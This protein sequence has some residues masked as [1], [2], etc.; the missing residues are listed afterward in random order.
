MVALTTYDDNFRSA[1]RKYKN[2]E[3]IPYFTPPLNYKKYISSPSIS[4]LKYFF[5]PAICQFLLFFFILNFEMFRSYR[6][7]QLSV[8]SPTIWPY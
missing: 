7:V 3:L 5:K 1:Q 2:N 4:S 8:S 6:K